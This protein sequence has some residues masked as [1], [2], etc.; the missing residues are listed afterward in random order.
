VYGVRVSHEDLVNYGKS[1]R[2]FDSR[3]MLNDGLAACLMTTILSQGVESRLLSQCVTLQYTVITI[4][5]SHHYVG[6]YRHL[7]VWYFILIPSLSIS[8]SDQSINSILPIIR[9]PK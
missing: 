1:R 9:L 3:Y 4:S 5:L 7:I 6:A 2:R 8:E